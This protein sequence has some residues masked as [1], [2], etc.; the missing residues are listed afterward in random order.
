M[1]YF[2]L[3]CKECHKT[4]FQ[5]AVDRGTL[6]KMLRA[7]PECPAGKHPVKVDGNQVMEVVGWGNSTP[8]R[9]GS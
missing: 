5:S 8:Y 4:W 9:A 6:N 3:L 7:L 2:Q 1:K